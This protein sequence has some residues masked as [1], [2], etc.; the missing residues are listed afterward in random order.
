MRFRLLLVLVLVTVACHQDLLD[1][2]LNQLMQAEDRRG[3]SETDI[4]TLRDGSMAGE[5]FMRRAATRALG[6]LERAELLPDILPLLEDVDPSVRATAATAVAQALSQ[7]PGIAGFEALRI[8][9]TTDPATSVAG[10]AAVSIGRLGYA[11][12]GAVQEAE[13]ALRAVAQQELARFGSSDVARQEE[14]P[15][16]ERLLGVVRGLETLFRLHNDQTPRPATLELLA[17][18]AALGRDDA[19]A[20]SARVRFLAVSAIA[21]AGAELPDELL[22]ALQRDPHVGVRRRAAGVIGSTRDYGSLLVARAL[23]DSE[24]RVRYAL[25][26]ALSRRA[27]ERGA[28]SRLLAGLRDEAAG[29]R[30]LTIDALARCDGAS[31]TLDRIASNIEGAGEADWHEPAHAL[32]ALAATDAATARS[33]AEAAIHHPV[34]QMRMYAA[35]AA[36]ASG[37]IELLR[38]LAADRHANVAAAAIA[39]LSA[40]AGSAGDDLYL[41]ALA[42]DDGQLLM[43]A[44]AALANGAQSVEHLLAALDRVSAHERETSRDPRRAL[45]EAIGSLGSTNNA[46]AV[47][48]Y[49]RD[50]DPVIA[51]TA[52]DILERWTGERQQPR[53]QLL[54]PSPFPS[55]EELEE[56]DAIHAVVRM[57]SGGEIVMLLHP[58]EAPSNA[59][60]F[61]RLARQGYLDGLTFHRVV[62]NFVIQ[63]GSP[64]ANEYAGDGP[65]TRDEIT[66]R[67]HLRGTVG[68]STRGR[69][70]G[71]AQIFVNLVDNVRLDFNYTIIGEVIEGMD[72]VDGILE[73][74]LIDT[75][76]LELAR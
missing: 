23:Q 42:S 64:G 6:R 9:M 4:S 3:F 29:V 48:V 7:S 26:E 13:A 34:W 56:I 46:E 28:C 17:E 14:T 38:P 74:A 52:A 50:F 2:P 73:G 69:D 40:G 15:R 59:A 36:T 62:A 65:F 41:A 51:T 18:L 27:P 66:S 11:D 31:A 19:A 76:L 16:I 53:P 72:V 71:D 24:A 47:G 63:G 12:V 22:F 75:V 10:A 35:R 60:R 54:P 55:A 44:A 61:V 45:L 57:R 21:D 39:G 58:L 25:L 30:L 20:G 43:A 67:S 37:W 8:S 68:I 70:T 5:V 49:L 32:L 1:S 33:H